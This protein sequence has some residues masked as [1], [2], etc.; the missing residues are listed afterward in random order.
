MGKVIRMSERIIQ[1]DQ[2]VRARDIM[3]KYTTEIRSQ[4]GMLAME[5]LVDTE[6]STRVVVVTEWE[7]RK[8]MKHWLKSPLCKKVVD[9]LDKVLDKPVSYRELMH[10]EGKFLF[11]QVPKE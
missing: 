11:L 5:T 9:E 2:A 10:H 7:S 4:P 1:P 6:D 3:A 8:H